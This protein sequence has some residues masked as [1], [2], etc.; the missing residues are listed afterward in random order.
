M[1]ATVVLAI[2]LW[3][4]LLLLAAQPT[5][6]IYFQGLGFTLSSLDGARPGRAE[7]RL[8]R[9]ANNQTEAVVMWAG[10]TLLA[11]PDPTVAGGLFLLSRLLY[12][13]VA[14]AGVPYL[15]ST[16]WLAG[17]AGWAGLALPTTWALWS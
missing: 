15:R 16:V 2:N 3:L 4:W 9:V 12:V 10:L 11:S 17:L 13:P 14:L 6:R 8:A 7:E 5:L 1:T